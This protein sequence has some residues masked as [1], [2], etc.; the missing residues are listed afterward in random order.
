MNY[1]AVL[2]GF[3]LL[4]L[5][6]I[7]LAIFANPAFSQEATPGQVFELPVGGIGFDA[8]LGADFIVNKPN[9]DWRVFNWGLAQ[10]YTQVAGYTSDWAFSDGENLDFNLGFRPTESIMG[11]LG[12]LAVGNY[13]DTYWRPVN[14]LHRITS[15]EE[16]T[17]NR[18]YVKLVRGELKYETDPFTAR[19]F[20]G[21]GHYHWQNEGDLFGFYPAQWEPDLYRDISTDCIPQGGEVIANTGLGR[22]QVVGGQPVW[23]SGLSFFGKY[24]L[25]LS[26]PARLSLVYRDEGIQWG[27][28]DERQRAVALT[29]RFTLQKYFPVQ[30]GIMTQSFR[31]DR[32]Y[33]YV[34]K[35]AKGTGDLGGEYLVK[36]AK[37][38]FADS[39]GA[40]AQ[41]ASD[42]LTFC[43]RLSLSYTY[44]G[45][46]AGN[47]HSIDTSLERIIT[48]PLRL[49]VGFTYQT[50][51]LGPVPFLYEGTPDNIGAPYARPRGKDSPFWVNWDNRQAYLGRVQL[52]FDPTPQTWFFRWEPNTIE[53]WNLNPSEDARLAFG[54]TYDIK[55][56]P[57]TTD[58]G[59]YFTRTGDVLWDGERD[60]SVVEWEYRP[61]GC[62]PTKQPIH[63][64]RLVGLLRAARGLNF[65]YDISGGEYLARQ[66]I[67]Y[68]E[69]TT[70]S[71]PT[72][73]AVKAMVTCDWRGLGL[74]VGYAQDAWGPEEWHERM[75][76]TYDQL[77]QTGIY[78]RLKHSG[79]LE[80]MLALDYTRIRETDKKYILAELG[81]FDEIRL[82]YKL[83]YKDIFVFIP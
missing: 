76:G 10:K 42:A 43:D 8:T 38:K 74:K 46:V 48:R 70:D 83:R 23:R 33:T 29:S 13:A 65:T 54:I 72:T 66:A 16:S 75:G 40:K 67:A 58:L 22:I 45:P 81:P 50:P 61:W 15:T 71:K 5:S 34:E 60:P 57:T 41:V 4:F 56:Y 7:F 44:L 25:P 39:L 82:T 73:T 36:T 53:P 69:S 49:V 2:K 20:R 31:L 35:V 63:S 51:V 24:D 9:D 52:I 79:M 77:W 37:T 68:T 78:Y 18:E 30:L 59:Y 26:K 28:E 17:G 32:E 55:Y 27:D 47:K 3:S 6:T 1:K 64:V 14:D 21:I 62:W 12:V 19:A 11:S 80:S